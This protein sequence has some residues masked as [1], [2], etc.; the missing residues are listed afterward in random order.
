MPTVSASARRRVVRRRAVRAAFASALLA[1]ALLA[2]AP[3]SAAAQ[4]TTKI[5]EIPAFVLLNVTPSDIARPTTARDLAVGLSNV[6][7]STGQARQGVGINFQPWF[8]F[9]AP[10][11]RKRYRESALWYS[12]ANLD[13]SFG[14]ARSAG[15]DTTS[16]DVALGAKTVFFDRSDPLASADVARDVGR[17]ARDLCPESSFTNPATNLPDADKRLKCLVT[18]TDSVYAAAARRGDLRGAAL[19]GAVAIGGR[20]PESRLDGLRYSGISTWLTGAF[21]ISRTG[22]FLLQSRFDRRETAD[23]TTNVFS[24]GARATFGGRRA[25]SF[26]EMLGQWSDRG[27]DRSSA[28]W[29]AGLE[30]LT[31]QELWLAVG[32]GSTFATQFR[33][34]PVRLIANVRWAL[35]SGPRLGSDDLAAVP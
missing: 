16:T 28:K 7:D 26:V 14:S 35:A 13:V 18:K 33:K 29:S 32:F 15:S 6:V 11:T 30:V 22:Q 4:A 10:V 12:L 24:T 20:L 34:D 25:N 31:A 1:S 27:R 8:T 5:P 17:V 19:S 3:A 23:S 9:G 2:A 21:P